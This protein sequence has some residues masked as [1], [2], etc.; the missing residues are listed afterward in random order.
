MTRARD[1]GRCGFDAI[2]DRSRPEYTYSV[3]EDAGEYANVVQNAYR[4]DYWATQPNYV[5]IWAEK[6]AIIGSI[7]NVAKKL[8]VIVRVGR[9]FLSTSKAHEIAKHFASINKPI[10]VLYLGDHDPSGQDIPRDMFDRIIEYGSG[11][12]EF[13]R[14]AIHRDDIETFDLPPLRAKVSDSRS[15]AF[16]SKY[17]S[18]CVELDALP[19]QELRRRIQ[20][21]VEGLQNRELWDMAVAVEKVELASIRDAG[22][23]WKNLVVPK[24]PGV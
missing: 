24:Q 10:T 5:E 14:I 16:T 3:F 15:S 22:R 4:K 20:S 2:V 18:H 7:E 13:T 19:P 8:G 12:F 6:D 11:W 17:G 23:M 21:A 1:D 9:G